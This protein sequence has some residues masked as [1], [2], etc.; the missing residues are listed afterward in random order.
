MRCAG[1]LWVERI[2]F[3]SSLIAR[4]VSTN[5]PREVGKRREDAWR[6]EVALDLGKPEFHLIQD[7]LLRLDSNQQPSG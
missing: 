4:D 6:E 3:G 2:G 7:W 5:L 1:L